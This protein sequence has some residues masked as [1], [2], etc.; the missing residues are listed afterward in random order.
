MEKIGRLSELE[1]LKNEC[2]RSTGLSWI[3]I[4][5]PFSVAGT[6]IWLPSVKSFSVTGTIIWLPSVKS[7]SVTG[8]IISLLRESKGLVHTAGELILESRDPI[9]P[10]E[11]VRDLTETKAVMVVVV[12][13]VV[14]IVVGMSV[15]QIERESI[16]GKEQRSGTPTVIGESKTCLNPSEK[17]Y[18]SAMWDE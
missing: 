2:L 13:V 5:E 11:E 17:S 4:T 12:V 3:L 1:F 14:V 16:C 7:F 18:V 6:I 9:R 8:T 15:K 10:K